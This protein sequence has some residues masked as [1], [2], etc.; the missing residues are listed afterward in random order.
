M[1]RTLSICIV[2]LACS[3]APAAAQVQREL[4]DCRGLS[5]EEKTACEARNN[6]LTSC[7]LETNDERFAACVTAALK[8]PPP[9][10]VPGF[11]RGDGGKPSQ[12][13]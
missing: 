12:G 6:A 1:K 11:S 3:A 7:R 13:K 4:A 10:R 9:V 5:A 2:L 8:N